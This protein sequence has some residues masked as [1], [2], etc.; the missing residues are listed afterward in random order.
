MNSIEARV[1]SSYY[2]RVAIIGVLTVGLGALL[3]LLQQ[4]RWAKV[5]DQAGVTRRDGKRFLWSNLQNIKFVHIR[6]Q[7]G[8]LGRLNH[9]ELIFHDGKATVFPL[10]LENRGEVMG[11]ISRLPGGQEAANYAS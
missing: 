4:R 11:F 6:L 7:S 10:M 2:V 3:M 5:F 9:I 8:R 1:K